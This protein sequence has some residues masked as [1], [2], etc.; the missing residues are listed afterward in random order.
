MKSICLI[1]P[2]QPGLREPT[3]YAPLGLLYIAAALE[4][5][6]I[7][8][9]VVNLAGEPEEIP[10][11]DF[12]GISVLSANVPEVKH[13][14][15]LLRIQ[16]PKS[17]I[18]LGGP[19]CTAMRDQIFSQCQCDYVID[20]EGEE[21]LPRLVKGTILYKY[22]VITA[23]R[24]YDLDKLAF[25]AR[26]M[27]DFEQVFNR[28]GVLIR[29]ADITTTII[30]SR[31]CPYHCAF[32][33]KIRTNDGVRYR[34]P[35]NII[36][37][38]DE[39]HN[40]FECRRFRIVDDAFTVDR[41]RVIEICD[42]L[43]QRDYAFCCILRADTIQDEHILWQMKEAGIAEVSIGVESADPILLSLMNK[44]ETIDEIETAIRLCNKVGI[45]V[46]AFLIE[47]L[48]GETPES[49]LLTK[50]FMQR[51][52][53]DSYTLARFTPLPGSHIWNFPE[54]FGM[55][56]GMIS[57]WFYPDDNKSEFRKWLERGDWR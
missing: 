24:L 51:C 8:V 27:L 46:K 48:P 38:L 57:D 5:Q 31:G 29:G 55:N 12:Y 40:R 10:E 6:N 52:R 54:K 7:P 2:P 25:P 30:T 35:Q 43:K 49:I 16:Y 37:E 14:C 42:L 18:I 39:I 22:G 28:T 20:G 13:L 19:H 34:S 15:N 23:P 44:R 41:P 17:K 4:K 33:C 26:H 45:Q 47:G 53:P 50:A 1:Y 21:V 11:A 56:C 9:R 3:A 32:C 36:E